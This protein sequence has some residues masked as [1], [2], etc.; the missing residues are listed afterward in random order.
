MAEMTVE[1]RDA[2]LKETRI[3]KLVTLY[4][5]GRPAVVPVWYEW[6]GKD[7]Y[8]F[9]GSDS[10]KVRQIGRASCRERV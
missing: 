10:E 1:Q 4:A 7:A 6:D 5:D 3:G 9:T 2:F 8:I